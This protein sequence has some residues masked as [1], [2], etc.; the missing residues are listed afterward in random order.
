MH[1][2]YRH[3]IRKGKFFL[4]LDIWSVGPPASTVGLISAPLCWPWRLKGEIPDGKGPQKWKGNG[5][6]V[7]M[8]QKKEFSSRFPKKSS[9]CQKIS[10][11]SWSRTCI[12][13]QTI[14]GTSNIA[15]PASCFKAFSGSSCVVYIFI[16]EKADRGGGGTS[17]ARNC[18]ELSVYS[19]LSLSLSHPFPRKRGVEPLLRT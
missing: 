11:S 16:R 7:K 14:Y 5:V 9:V 10:T 12:L 18:S 17:P 8:R 6:R 1:K 4:F 15:F 3:C 13:L 19:S 2:H